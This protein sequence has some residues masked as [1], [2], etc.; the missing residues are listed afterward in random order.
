M[1][2]ASVNFSHRTGYLAQ[3]NQLNVMKIDYIHANKTAK[4]LLGKLK[5]YHQVLALEHAFSRF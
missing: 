3:E 5:G 4:L 1:L 2:N